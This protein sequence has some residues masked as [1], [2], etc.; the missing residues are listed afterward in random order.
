MG[1]AR[2]VPEGRWS[3]IRKHQAMAKWRLLA[4][5]RFLL[6]DGRIS[7]TAAMSTF[8]GRIVAIG[9][10][11]V[12]TESVP[13]GTPEADLGGGLAVPGLVDCHVHLMALGLRLAGER[14]DLASTRSLSE[15]LERVRSVAATLPADEW[16]R[17]GGWDANA[18][19]DGRRPSA[20]DLDVIVADRPVILTS[21]CG[22]AAW[23]SSAALRLAGI[24][25]D[26]PE[27]EGGHIERDET[28]EPTGLLFENAI[29]LVHRLRPELTPERARGAL[30]AAV[31]H[32]HS[33]GVVGCHNCEGPDVL[34]ALCDLARNDE[35]RL[36]VTQHI[37][38][39]LLEQLSDLGA[40]PGLG[41]D[42]LRLG[43]L[44]VFADGSLGARTA[45]MLEPY[46]DTGG[47]GILERD[48][49]A[50]AELAR[51][52][53]VAG[54]GLAVHAIGDRAVR[55]VLDG[56]ETL[57][58]LSGGVRR[59]QRIEHAQHVQQ[60]DVARFAE[61]GIVASVQPVHLRSDMA[62]VERTLSDRRERAF[63][64]GSLRRA[65]ATLCLGS[66]AP[67]ET[68]DPLH[69]LRAAVHRRDW[70]GQPVGG[71]LP[72]ERL[73]VRDAVAG[74][75]SAAS[76]AVHGAAR[77]GMLAAGAHADLTVFSHD[78][79]ANPEALDECQVTATV[80][81]G[82]VVYQRPKA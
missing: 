23:V 34:R 76:V 43:S 81:G 3:R 29:D 64:Y 39:A 55:E 32:A 36:R 37:P 2:A 78:I 72:D 12:V 58:D 7:E 14:L 38:E 63:P 17:G 54:M 50:I 45:A 35:L 13:A 28:G 74:Y 25:R 66:D 33:L 21:R 79:I 10:R 19:L 69:G 71:W 52:A 53:S 11:D 6:P 4:N 44:K 16:I 27:T 18:W 20:R 56:L 22:H 31:G 75:T 57:A 41:G 60:D 40:A 5:A 46:R 1:K 61:L 73:S 47:T 30:L 42:W 80:V 26:G 59:V 24:S 62:I 82:E 51:R 77:E 15:C 65:G 8:A 67:V 48:A 68:L 70:D 49:T 9:P